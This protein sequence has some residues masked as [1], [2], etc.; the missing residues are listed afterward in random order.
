MG[1]IEIIVLEQQLKKKENKGIL[2]KNLCQK[3]ENLTDS[4][5]KK[6][7]FLTLMSVKKWKL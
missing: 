7:D 1:K 5:E 2:W 4:L 6:G 3:F